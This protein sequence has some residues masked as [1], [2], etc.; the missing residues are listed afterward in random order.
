MDITTEM[1]SNAKEMTKNI[2]CHSYALK[3]FVPVQYKSKLLTII[4]TDEGRVM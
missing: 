3:L 4:A 2:F 1:T